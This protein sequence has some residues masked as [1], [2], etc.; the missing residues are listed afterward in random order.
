MGALRLGHSY[1]ILGAAALMSVVTGAGAVHA[2]SVQ[3]TQRVSNQATGPLIAPA[4]GCLF[5]TA[6]EPVTVTSGPVP[7]APKTMRV[8]SFACGTRPSAQEVTAAIKSGVSGYD[9]AATGAPEATSSDAASSN[10]IRPFTS[11][12]YRGSWGTP[13][14]LGQGMYAEWDVFGPN[15]A[16]GFAFANSSNGAVLQFLIAQ[17]SVGA[18]SFKIM[19]GGISPSPSI[20]PEYVSYSDSNNSYQWD[21]YYCY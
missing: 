14:N 20:Q 17:T 8:T 13:C 21:Y 1:R 16:A 5:R 9:A 12:T 3:Q 7:T 18:G 11:Y 2:S 10:A 19:G 4:R 6:D 15:S